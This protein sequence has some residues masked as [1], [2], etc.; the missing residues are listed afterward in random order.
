LLEGEGTIG[1]NVVNGGELNPGVDIFV[2]TLA[3]TGNYTQTA[4]GVVNIKI[5]GPTE[6]DYDHLVVQGT[7]DLDAN[8]ATLNVNMVYGFNPQGGESFTVMTFGSLVGQFASINLPSFDGGHFEAQY[9][10]NSLN[11]VAVSDG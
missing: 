6:E 9:Q 8:G 2:G 11:L 7:A 5:G 1:A 3:I 10:D 4:T